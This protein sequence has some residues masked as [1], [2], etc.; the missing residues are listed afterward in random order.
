[1]QRRLETLQQKVRSLEGKGFPEVHRLLQHVAPPPRLPSLSSAL[2]PVH[3]R[4]AAA[5]G[6]SYTAMLLD[7]F[8]QTDYTDVEPLGSAGALRARL[9]GRQG[10]EHKL[11]KTLAQKH[12]ALA[13]AHLCMAHSLRH[14]RLLPLECAFFEGETLFLQFPWCAGGRSALCL[15][16]LRA[17]LGPCGA[18]TVR[19][20]S[21]LPSSQAQPASAGGA[22]A[23]RPGG[24]GRHPCSRL[25]P[26]K[27]QAGERSACGLQRQQ[28]ARRRRLGARRRGARRRRAGGGLES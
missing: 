19:Q 7:R 4:S 18:E 11:V 26:R 6:A 15:Q 25:G 23:S 16:L 12:L 14:R 27:P 3:R 1:M 20:R 21:L 2:Q 13:S 5:M 9:R 10:S 24:S 8:L 22:G 17:L 28:G